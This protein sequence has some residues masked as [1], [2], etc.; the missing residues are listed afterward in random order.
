MKKQLIAILLAGLALL[1]LVPTGYG[2]NSAGIQW[3]GDYLAPNGKSP[4]LPK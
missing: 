2:S 1:G 3:L 4:L